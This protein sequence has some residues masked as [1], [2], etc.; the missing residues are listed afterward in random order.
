MVPNIEDERECERQRKHTYTCKVNTRTG[1][2]V[3]R[4]NLAEEEEEADYIQFFLFFLLA[5]CV[6]VFVRPCARSFVPDES[7]TTESA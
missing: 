5:L 2:D 7:R 1:A 6:C 3:V 4:K